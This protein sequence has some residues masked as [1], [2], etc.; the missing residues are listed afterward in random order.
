MNEA[1]R[2]IPRRQESGPEDGSGSAADNKRSSARK[3]TPEPSLRTTLSPETHQKLAQMR[4]ENK[5]RKDIHTDPLGPVDRENLEDPFPNDYNI[6]RNKAPSDSFKKALKTVRQEHSNA[7]VAQ[8]ETPNTTNEIKKSM[9]SEKY[10]DI[11]PPPLPQKEVAT[12]SV[13]V[14]D[15]Q[16]LS[17]EKEKL[18]SITTNDTVQQDA[19]PPPNEA[20]T[21]VRTDTQKEVPTLNEIPQK[22]NTAKT[23][24]PRVTAPSGRGGKSVAGTKSIFGAGGIGPD[25]AGSQRR[26]RRPITEGLSVEAEENDSPVVKI[27]MIRK[28]LKDTYNVDIK[29]D[30]TYARGGLFG[31]NK[32]RVEKLLKTDLEFKGLV[33]EI[34]TLSKQT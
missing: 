33:D 19:A 21:T 29:E 34:V 25:T 23:K 12:P 15:D 16:S 10:N 27:E 26:E 3:G 7:P 31:G 4:K 32:R 5:I 22:Q 13:I 18:P 1:M 30:G 14:E 28:K 20:T 17:T 24:V 6:D 8:Q 11:T 2:P 9:Q